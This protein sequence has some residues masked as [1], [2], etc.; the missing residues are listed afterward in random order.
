MIKVSVMYP[1]GDGHTFDMAYYLHKHM[2]TVRQKLGG[3][4]KGVAVDEGL[5]GGEPGSR[6]AFL[7]LCHLLFESVEAF[8]SSFAEHGQALVNDIPNFTNAVPTIQIN[9]VKL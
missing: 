3:A 2:P 9:E 1:N 8:Q 4:L 6:P 7:L 5:A